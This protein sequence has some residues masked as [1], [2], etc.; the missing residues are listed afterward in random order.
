LVVMS[1]GQVA[2]DRLEFQAADIMKE[3]RVP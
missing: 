3:G 2:V 1:D